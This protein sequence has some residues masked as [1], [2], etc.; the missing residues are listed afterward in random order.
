M[1]TCL[2]CDAGKGS[3]AG[4]DAAD[5]CVVCTG[6]TANGRNCDKAAM[7]VPLNCLQGFVLDTSATPDGCVACGVSNCGTCTFATKADEC[8]TCKAGFKYTAKTTTPAAAGTC[9]A[10]AIA[11]CDT[12]TVSGSPAVE[13][14]SKC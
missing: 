13:S 2:W 5:D 4:S 12:C 9:T 14:C 7:T 1:A 8:D 11:G 3:D 6:L 10:C